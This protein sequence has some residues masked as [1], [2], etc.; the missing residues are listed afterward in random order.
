MKS[1]GFFG[2]LMDSH[3]FSVGNVLYS[4]AHFWDT[5]RNCGIP[6]SS[7]ME[8]S[9]FCEASVMICTITF[10]FF[11]LCSHS[12][13]THKANWVQ[14][15]TFGKWRQT[16]ARLMGLWQCNNRNEIWES[17]GNQRSFGQFWKLTNRSGCEMKNHRE[18]RG[19]VRGLQWRRGNCVVLRNL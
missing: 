5:A 18:L 9:C 16:E 12:N 11:L 10:F 4:R 3:G 8:T 6:K 13:V 14:V 19:L 1:A 15:E 17:C 7:Q 2:S